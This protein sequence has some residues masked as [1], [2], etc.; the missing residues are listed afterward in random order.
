MKDILKEYGTTI[1]SFLGGLFVIIMAFFLF[2]GGLAAK[3]LMR[4]IEE[5]T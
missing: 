3:I 1:L 4:L 5:A 2:K